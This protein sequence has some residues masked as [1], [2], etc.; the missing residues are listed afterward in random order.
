M[1]S[2]V[3]KNNLISTIILT[4]SKVEH[5][6]HSFIYRPSAFFIYPV[7]YERLKMIL[8][9]AIKEQSCGNQY[10]NIRNKDRITRFPFKNIDYFKSTQRNVILYASESNYSQ[11]FA[12][13]LD[14]AYSALPHD[15]F[16]RCHQ[17]FIVNLDNVKVLDKTNKQ[18]IMFSGR[19]ADISKR[20]YQD[21]VEYFNL[22]IN[23]K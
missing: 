12:G 6:L 23:K 11:V 1:A 17:S 7:N 5:V 13:K 9:Y 20:N 19:T 2:L 22:Y 10:F 15:N 8:Q 14:E 16:I 21:V 18:F 4:G 3:R